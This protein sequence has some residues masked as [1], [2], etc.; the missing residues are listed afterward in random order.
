MSDD[1]CGN[2]HKCLEGMVEEIHGLKISLVA[3]RMILCATCGNKRCPKASDH[4]LLCTG[5]NAPG[6]PG[7]V[8]KFNTQ[9]PERPSEAL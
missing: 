6:Q 1:Y 5:S 4:K 8:Y 2:C 3:T 7:S 9:F